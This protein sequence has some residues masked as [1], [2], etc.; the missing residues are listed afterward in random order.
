M[1]SRMS[2]R[3]WWI[4]VIVVACCI[5]S[6]LAFGQTPPPAPTVL[7]QFRT[8]GVPQAERFNLVQSRLH[9]EPGAATPVHTHPGQVVVTI[10]EG[11]N[12]FTMN[13]MGHLYRAGESFVE[14]PGETMQA[15]NAGTTRMSVMA[16]YLLPWGAPL[17]QP[18]PGDT[19]PLP[20]PTTSYQFKT[21]VAP[22][23]E[24]FDVV[25]QELEFAPGAAT[26]WHT[27]PG[28]VMVTVLAGELTFT[29][30]GATTIYR[31]G[32]SFVEA[33]DQLAQ[34]RNASG[35]ATRVM[36]SYLL[37]VGAPLSHPQAAPGAS[38]SAEAPAPATLP[39]TGATPLAGPPA[40]LAILAGA[41]LLIGGWSLRQRK[42][43]R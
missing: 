7:W 36:A 26:P 29:Y 39:N 15:R 35:A 28:L 27:H 18:V 40:W 33:P 32:E 20:R 2:P 1:Q 4:L 19:T 17:S 16:T 5:P 6:S 13:G 3:R 14:L 34:A 43:E 23:P 8:S 10:L 9:F 38:P 41:G 30:Q 37:P 42:I 21:D 11:E 24:P 22:M 12:T 25:Q 31:E